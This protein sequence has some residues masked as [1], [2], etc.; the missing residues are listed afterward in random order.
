MAVR[1]E[2][3]SSAAETLRAMVSTAT[4]KAAPTHTDDGTSAKWLLP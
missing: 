4:M 1:M 3:G 2:S